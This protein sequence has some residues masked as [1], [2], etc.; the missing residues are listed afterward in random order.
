MA[1]I[2]TDV[3]SFG[4]DKGVVGRAAAMTAE[5]TTAL[6]AAVADAPAGDSTSGFSSTGDKATAVAC[7]NRNKVRI[8]ELDVLQVKILAR[9]KEVENILEN[10]GLAATN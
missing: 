7:I 10:V 2:R 8:G 1:Q 5:D 6:T 4:S 3:G 9:I